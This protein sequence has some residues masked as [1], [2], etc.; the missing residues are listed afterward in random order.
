[1]EQC[2]KFSR[3][4]KAPSCHQLISVLCYRGILGRENIKWR[5]SSTYEPNNRGSVDEK[6]KVAMEKLIYV[7]K[8]RQLHCGLRHAMEPIT[9]DG[10][11]T[12]CR[13]VEKRYSLFGK[14]WRELKRVTRKQKRWRVSVLDTLWSPYGFYGYHIWVTDLT[15]MSLQ[16]ASY[17][18][19]LMAYMSI[20]C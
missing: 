15:N 5:T 20:I 2:A 14:S 10:R 12:W 13:A 16:L 9:S 6:G 8:E 1:M 17:E 3:F 11:I 4:S 7:K 18:Q 19:K